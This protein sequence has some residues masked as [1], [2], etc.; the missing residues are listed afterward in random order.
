MPDELLLVETDAPYLSPQPVRGKPNEPANVG[1]HRGVRRRAARRR[2]RGARGGGRRERGA[3]VRVVSD[4]PAEPEPRQASL[5]R[6]REFDVRPEPGARPELP[7]RRQHPRRD[8]PRRRSSTPTDVVLEVGGGLGVL[9]EY[10]APRGRA[11][12]RRRGRPRARAARSRD[13]LDPFAQRD[14]AHRRRG[15]ARLRRARPRAGQG[16]REPAVR[17]RGDGAPE[18][19]RGAAGRAALGGDGAARGRRS[20][21]P[22]R[23]GSKTY[24]ATSVLA[25]LAC[26]VRVLRRVPRTVFHPVPNVES[27]LVALRR[28][29]PAPAP[30]VAGAR[31][32]R[33]SRTGAR[34]SP[35]RSRSRPARPTDIRDARP[36][37]ARRA[38][39]TR[40]TPA[41]SGSRPEDFARSPTLLGRSAWRP[42]G[43]R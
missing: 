10:L 3:R 16:R 8:R 33:R 11:P 6:L 24:G 13:A 22:P 36:R 19:G 14:A 23:P 9:S 29:A 2:V 30:A 25:Q 28:R 15:R 34:R 43:R 37:R 38:S 20:G 42:G 1:A 4:G 7:D 21:S 17:G 39:A 40:R 27:A 12:A 26:D 5:R 31:A 41:P 32:R 18:V 35:G